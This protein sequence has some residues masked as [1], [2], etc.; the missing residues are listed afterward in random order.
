MKG[1]GTGIKM[2][3]Q[4]HTPSKCVTIFFFPPQIC[5][6]IPLQTSKCKAGCK[7]KKTRLESKERFLKLK[8]FKMGGKKK[9]KKKKEKEMSL[10]REI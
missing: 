8:K 3:E 4:F 6:D 10:R 2:L 7:K 9:K 5:Q 1:K